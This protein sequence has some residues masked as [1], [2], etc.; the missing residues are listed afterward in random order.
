MKIINIYILLFLTFNCFSQKN[1]S[2]GSVIYRV[3]V[4]NLKDTVNVKNSN[5][6]FYKRTISKLNE[7]RYRLDFNNNK[8]IFILE[9][10][11]VNDKEKNNFF[12]KSAKLLA[13]EEIYYTDLVNN[14]VLI[15]QEFLGDL[16]LVEQSLDVDWKMTK[17]TKM[18]ENFRCI[19]AETVVKKGKTYTE[20]IIVSAW[21]APELTI[22]FGPK[23]Y[24]GL[25]GLILE[26]SFGDVNYFVS[27]IEFEANPKIEKPTEGIKISSEKFETYILQKVDEYGFEKQRKQN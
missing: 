15:Q 9:D 8:S 10:F 27:K 11:L 16:F 2:S 12:L 1:T 24:G 3:G 5:I 19:K 21:F 7:I 14:K 4:T 25:P 26:L 23:G 22:A 18:I 6:D 17:E 13:G 20:D